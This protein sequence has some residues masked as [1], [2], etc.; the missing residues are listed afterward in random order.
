MPGLTAVN[1]AIA[2]TAMAYDGTYNFGITDALDVAAY[3]I[4]ATLGIT[5]TKPNG[6]AATS[7]STSANRLVN[8]Y[9]TTN[10][11]NGNITMF[12]ENYRFPLST[13]FSVIPGGITGNWTSPTALSNGNLQLFD[14][15]WTYPAINFTSGYL[16]VQGGGVNYSTF[17][18]DQVAVWAV[19]IG[20]AHS[21]MSIVF[22]GVTV[23][24]VSADGTGSLNVDVRLPSETAWL[25][26]GRA[27]GDGNGCQ[28]GTS[29]GSTFN[30]SFGAK[31]STNSGGIV[32][33]RVTLRSSGAARATQMV[34][35][36]T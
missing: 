33:I 27:F 28:V 11:T 24:N 29:S 3:S 10:S 4:N 2:G 19:N 22:T 20:V 5:A 12:D 9:S 18:G 15:K 31:T 35:T 13:D 36:G 30:L 7:T 23:A 8:T 17:S 6:A 21:S 14:S 1:V 32:F 25:D 26:A 16:P 34:V